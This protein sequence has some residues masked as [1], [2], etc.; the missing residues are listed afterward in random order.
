MISSHIASYAIL[1]VMNMQIE[2]EMCLYQCNSN[3]L[4][5][6]I[7]QKHTSKDWPVGGGIQ[8]RI[9]ILDT[10]YPSISEHLAVLRAH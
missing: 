7:S 1:F 2:W 4:R 10:H 8:G 6:C 9:L 3:L 5:H